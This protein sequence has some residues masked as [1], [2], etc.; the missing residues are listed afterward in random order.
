MPCLFR[1]TDP[2][3]PPLMLR[4]LLPA[5][6]F[7]AS[8]SAFAE[9]P[10]V[11]LTAGFHRIEAEVAANQ[12]DRSQGLMHR[13]A[14]PQ[15]RGMIF[16]F[17]VSAVHCFWMKNTPLPLSIAFLDEKGVIV[18]IDEMVPETETSHCPSRPARFALEMNA[19]WFK[20]RGLK[21]GAVIGGVER[22]PPGR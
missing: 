6:L 22:L 15:N 19:G 8:A 9:L 17:P 13:R 21:P 16:V 1:S 11:E 5:I 18:D 3:R 2:A 14:M 20:A 12:A 7:A 4:K 10:V